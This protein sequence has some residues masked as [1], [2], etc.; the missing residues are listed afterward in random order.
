MTKIIESI[1][2]KQQK[3][4]DLVEMM[5][6]NP[7]LGLLE[8]KAQDA[9]CKM[10]EEEGF[11]VKR[12]L[13]TPTDFVAVYDT[14]K[15]GASIAFLCEYDALPA[16]GHGCGHNLIAGTSLAAAVALK[17]ASE[18]LCGKIYVMGTPAEETHG[19]KIMMV[20]AGLFE[21]IDAA[22]M[23]H[24]STINGTG[25]RTLA[26]NPIRFEFHGK[27]AHACSPHEGHSALDAAVS[28]YNQIS[29]LR[30]FT[31]PHTFIHGVITDGG[32][33]ANVIPD[34][35]CMDYYFRGT[36]MDY[37]ME[38]SDRALKIAQACA[39]ANMCTLETS[40]YETAYEDN[41]INYGLANALKEEFAQL[42][43]ENIE[44]VDEIPNGSSDIGSVSYVCPS[45]HGYIKIAADDVAGHSCE[46][47][48]ATISDEGHVAL[49]VGAISLANIGYRLMSDHS[50]LEDIRSEFEREA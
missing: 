20:D 40:I 28:F 8:Y 39:D 38:L 19:G 26:I 25:G 24:P 5:Y 48:D 18:D 37:V 6:N 49:R 42:G 15:E 14:K 44:D 16:V 17:D 22:M 32:K 29:M 2:S 31:L 36:K 43:L 47:A 21:G 23:I 35:A 27:S 41:K 45:L 7:E 46:M 12:G 4:E 1:E 30:Q 33:A 34:Y 13:S 10:L 9:L 11:D 3:Y 50:F